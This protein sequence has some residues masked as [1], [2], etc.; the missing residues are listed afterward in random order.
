[1]VTIN[2][3]Y[4][5][6]PLQNV[7]N[8]QWQTNVVVAYGN[9]GSPVNIVRFIKMPVELGA[10][11]SIPTKTFVDGNGNTVPFGAI[12]SIDFRGFTRAADP[13]GNA[14][15]FNA[16]GV[17]IPSITP[18][19]PT[20]K[21]KQIFSDDEGAVYVTTSGPGGNGRIVKYQITD[22]EITDT[23][24]W[25]INNVHRGCA[26]NIVD[27]NIVTNNL[28]AD[29][30]ET[31]DIT[32]GALI[33]DVDVSLGG[34]PRI[35]D[36]TRSGRMFG[37]ITPAFPT[38]Q[39]VRGLSAAGATL[40]T[41]SM[42]FRSIPPSDLLVCHGESAV[43]IVAFH[44]ENEVTT[45]TNELG[46]SRTTTVSHVFRTLIGLNADTGAIIY[47]SIWGQNQTTVVIDEI[48]PP[49]TTTINSFGVLSL[50]RNE[51]FPPRQ[52]GL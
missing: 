32:T 41:T 37:F 45:E 8:V 23:I 1:M 34:G 9:Q 3:P 44:Q 52:I 13:D 16:G 20:S 38:P 17:V 15:F 14:K 51:Y 18:I 30:I 40:W 47:N 19:S 4:R 12:I 7:V 50:R 39:Q 31:W 22:E 10:S 27:G 42:P 6:D 5:F 35:G 29:F 48:T 25:A 46:Q 43:F 49:N 28:A 36:V 2:P 33:S 26:V 24:L 21:G 11:Q